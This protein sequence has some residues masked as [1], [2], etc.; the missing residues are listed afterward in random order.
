MEVNWVNIVISW[1][2]CL[3][4]PSVEWFFFF[5]FI[6]TW[7]RSITASCDFWEFTDIVYWL[8]SRKFVTFSPE[9]KFGKRCFRSYQLP[10]WPTQAFFTSLTWELRVVLGQRLS[11]VTF[12]TYINICWRRGRDVKE[13]CDMSNNRIF[14]VT[15][16]HQK[17]IST[18]KN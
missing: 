8:R 4:D 1:Q 7:M 16:R 15:T 13:T 2:M 17:K 14:L 6:M 10:L 5:F 3:N 18:I 9:K 12:C 11:L